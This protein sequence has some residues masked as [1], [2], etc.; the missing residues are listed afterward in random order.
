MYK[1]KLIAEFIFIIIFSIYIGNFYYKKKRKMETDAR[2]PQKLSSTGNLATNWKRWRKEFNTY[3][4]ITKGYN[5]PQEEQVAWLENL[6]GPIGLK[7]LEKITFNNHNDEMTISIVLEKLDQFFNPAKNEIEERYKFFSK[8]K[9][10][11]ESI[12][13]FI[14]DL[15]VRFSFYYLLD[16]RFYFN[17]S[18]FSNFSII[19][20]FRI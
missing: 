20:H 17:I 4:I 14:R 1:R 3:M 5:K 12:D 13:T 7:A 15:T 2:P 19:F 16:I 18:I 10:G 8:T 6:I 9:K 11:N